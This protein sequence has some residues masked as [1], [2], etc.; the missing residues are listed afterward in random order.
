[1]C[2]EPTLGTD[3]ECTWYQ[4]SVPTRDWGPTLGTDLVELG[5][6]TWYQ[7]GS[8]GTI[9]LY[10]HRA[11]VLTIGTDNQYGH[12]ALGTDM[13]PWYRHSEPTLGT[14]AVTSNSQA[15]T[16]TINAAIASGMLAGMPNCKSA[17]S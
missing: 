9:T 2:S 4:P 8:P 5:T 3:T 17:T 16:G 15:R 14:E 13:G 6:G 7:T 12:G 10:R 1:M 11:S